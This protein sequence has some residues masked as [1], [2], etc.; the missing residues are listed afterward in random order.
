MTI[1]YRYDYVPGVEQLIRLYRSARLPRPLQDLPRMGNLQAHA[2]LWITAWDA[3]QL[4]GV[5]R[6]LTDFSWCCY[7]A[8]L[9]VCE[10]YQHRG[11]G[12]EL[13]ALTKQQVGP[14]CM[15]LL[16]SVQTALDYYPKIGMES[17][18]NGFILHRD[19]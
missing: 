18:P 15:V 16:L 7:L 2:N 17:V 10:N 11:I 12:R 19:Q 5:A 9:A 13:V 3:D 8:D 4:V 1:T 6:S 14:E